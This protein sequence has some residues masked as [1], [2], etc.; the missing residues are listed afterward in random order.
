LEPSANPNEPIICALSWHNL[1]SKPSYTAISYF[2]GSDEQN[3]TIIL[4]GKE[5]RT[6]ASALAALKGLRSR[7]LKKNFW[8]DAICIDQTSDADKAEQICIMSDIYRNAKQVTV[9]L[10]PDENGT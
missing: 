4:N 6:T 1:N 9:W 3:S 8:I 7:W 5:C 2:W 10:G